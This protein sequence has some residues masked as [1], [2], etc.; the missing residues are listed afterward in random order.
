MAITVASGRDSASL[1]QTTPISSSFTWYQLGSV[2]GHI[3]LGGTSL[4]GIVSGAGAFHYGGAKLV[5]E[6]T[7]V[8]EFST[9]WM[10][11]AGLLAVGGIG[12]RR[13]ALSQ[14]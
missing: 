6:Y 2:L 12:A 11:V 8:A 13:R 10:L 9:S 14:V 5:L 3:A 4:T 1:F 7:P